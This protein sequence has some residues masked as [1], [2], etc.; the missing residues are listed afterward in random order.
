M[1]LDD[2]SKEELKE[3]AFECSLSTR[4]ASCVLFPDRFSRP[5]SLR[6]HDPIFQALDDDSLHYVCIAAARGVG[7]STIAN[8]GF[9]AKKLL[10]R[11][12]N[13]VLPIC[14]SESMAVIRSEDLKRELLENR[15]INKLFG[16]LK[17]SSFGKD[18]W[19]TASNIM[20]YPRGAGQQVRGLLH[21]GRRPD[22]LLIDDYES[23]DSTDSEEQRRKKLQFFFSD[24]LNCIDTMDPERKY[25]IIVLGNILHEDSLVSRLLDDP[26]WHG[27]RVGL[28]DENMV[29]NYPEVYDDAAIAR[30][31]EKFVKQG[32]LDVFYREYLCIA[33]G[34]ELASFRASM[35]RGYDERAFSLSHDSNVENYVII[36]PAKTVTPHAAYSAIIGVAIDFEHN[37]I[38]VRDLIN[39]RLH[40]ND[41]ID[42]G[43]AM[44]ERLRARILAYEETSLNEFISYPINAEIARR[45]LPIQA[46]G[47]KAR[48]KKEE[49]VKALIPFYRRGLIYHNQAV[50]S[51]LEAQLLSFPRAK[52]WDL[53]DALAYV[54]SLL[55]SGGRY[56][57][58][59]ESPD[60]D[61]DDPLDELS[62]LE[63]MDQEDG[64]ENFEVEAFV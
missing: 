33:S 26:N 11:E 20:V 53:M 9:L 14:Y 21:Q 4:M 39:A 42:E 31:R 58:A 13:F 25:R 44:C 45:G 17:S 63:K 18:C 62:V 8:M 19:I 30:I 28:A 43:L 56:F 38:Y 57:R 7:K 3:L 48:G 52:F 15:V 36:D 32:L 55:D 6:I 64:Y 1:N 59:Q 35:F 27:V 5:F 41:L 37:C 16:S 22:L 54:V 2:L 61:F 60:T 34:G 50:T 24:I 40:P 46:I 49:R 51:A 29:S 10:F 47:L 23:S 12:C